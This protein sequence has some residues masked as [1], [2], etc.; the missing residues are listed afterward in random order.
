MLQPRFERRASHSA[1][2][3]LEQ[4]RFRA[5]LD[6]LRLR[7][8][9]GEADPEL[10]VWWEALF[11][12]GDEKRRDL[13]DS[14]RETRGPRRVKRETTRAPAAGRGD[15]DR[16]RANEAGQRDAAN[17]TAEASD[18][19]EPADDGSAAPDAAAP[20]KRRRRRRRPADSAG[21]PS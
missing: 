12:A 19:G 20:R 18:S 7:G 8:E 10:A 13:L 16:P 17:D 15:A 6:F 2:A 1:L 11:Q 21:T 14:V 4:P 5:G 9:V 3:L